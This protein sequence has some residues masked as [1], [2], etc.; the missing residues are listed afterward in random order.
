MFLLLAL[1]PQLIGHSSLNW[2]VRYLPAHIVTVALLGEPVLSTVLAIPIL[3]E[4]PG[5]LLVMGGA[6]TLF[7]V[8]LALR[9]EVRNSRA[10]EAADA[11]EMPSIEVVPAAGPSLALAEDDPRAR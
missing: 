1:V 5:L 2:A 10:V 9:E 3:G 4:R 7:G 8:Y 11:G 6:I